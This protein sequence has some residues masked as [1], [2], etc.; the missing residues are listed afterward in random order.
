MTYT[1][2]VSNALS[3]PLDAPLLP[4]QQRAVILAVGSS[5]CT[6]TARMRL[7]RFNLTKAAVDHCL[8]VLQFTNFVIK[9]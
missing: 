6:E 3:T 8:K 4:V 1:K 7:P 9:F 2:Q 5:T